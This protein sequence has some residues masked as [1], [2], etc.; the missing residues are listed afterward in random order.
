MSTLVVFLPDRPRLRAGGQPAATAAAEGFDW[1]HWPAEGLSP[2]SGH[3]LPA[4][5]PAAERIVGVLPPTAVGWHRL[6][7]P[8]APPRQR[9]AALAGVL[10][11]AVL[12]D[13]AQLHY[14]LP[15]GLRG[16]QTGWIAV[17]DK[18][19]LAELLARFDAAGRPIQTL[20]PALAPADEPEAPTRLWIEAAADRGTPPRLQASLA[21]AE[22][23]RHWPLDGSGARALLPAGPGR[24]L[25]QASPGAAAAAEAWLN[26]PVQVH[27]RIEQAREA[28]AS[29]WNLRQFDLASRHRGWGR[30]REA[31]LRF[32]RE[33]LWR[34][35][36]WG[37]VALLLVQA[38]GLQLGA[39]QL[40]RALAADRAE[41]TRL[42]RE[43]FPQLRVVLDAPRQM[44]TETA[45][46]R[47]AAGEV[48][49]ADLEAALA[50]LASVWPEGVSADTLSYENRQLRLEATGL[51][52]P[53]TEALASGLAPAGWQVDAQTGRLSLRR[54]PPPGAPRAE[55]RP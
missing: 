26:Q 21:D 16:G 9:A 25:V 24:L 45:R 5:L 46:L 32:L 40:Q 38:L 8:K 35:L 15:P 44:Q 1:V 51:R 36:R 20:V 33:P 31:G 4:G 37:L 43:S 7:C 34:P 48:G 29:P 54:T 19:G 28:L 41:M 52:S 18:A 14:A 47:H 2:H 6:A 53:A 30:L 50:A 55:D 27:G 42:L 13:A 10:E 11:E 22:G 49:E 12:E 17:T 23:L 3:G 39:W